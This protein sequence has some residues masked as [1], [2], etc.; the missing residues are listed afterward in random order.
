MAEVATAIASAIAAVV[1][2]V[3]AT[4]SWRTSRQLEN[5][6][7]SFDLISNDLDR[8][9]KIKLA[10]IGIT[11]PTEARIQTAMNIEDKTERDGNLQAIL[12]EIA[13]LYHQLVE[14]FLVNEDVFD[15]FSRKEFSKLTEGSEN[16]TGSELLGRRLLAITGIGKITVD[17][18]ERVRRKFSV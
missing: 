13:P 4:I 15:E 16:W 12:D 14:T 5:V 7:R 8:L 1:S 18:I 6:K 2:L 10:F 3:V 9:L 11:V 17:Q